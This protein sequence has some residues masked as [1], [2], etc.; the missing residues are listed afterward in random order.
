MK[1]NIDHY[2]VM[3]NPVAH[4]KSPHIHT[5]FAHHTQQSLQYDT[6]LV[7]T[8]TGEFAQAVQTFQQTAGLGLNITVP[9]KQTAWNLVDIRQKRAERAEAVN[10]LWFDEQGR[11]IGDNTDGVGLVR[12]LT[13][14][15]DH[16][17]TDKRVLILGAGGAVRG[18]LA[19]LLDKNPA[20]CVIINRTASKAA[21]L[22]KLFADLGNISMS[23]HDTLQSYDLII[24]GTSASLHGELP[25]LPDN[26]LNKNSC[27]YDMMYANTPTPFLQWAKQQGALLAIDGL[28]MLVEQAAESFY[29]W[30]GVRPDTASVIKQMRNTN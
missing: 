1:T 20:Q 16:Q 3:G 11:I 7:G 9:F 14:N 6:I 12:D 23:T 5:A 18:I 27:C 19:P 13:Q 8:K 15:H 17:I 30:R 29:L 28:G 10:T 2:A 26:I 4:S 24:N 25:A 21:T 22:V